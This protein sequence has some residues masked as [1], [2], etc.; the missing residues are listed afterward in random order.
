MA[1]LLF[2]QNIEYGFLGPM[3]IAAAIKQRHGC[4][5][6]IARKNGDV[7]AAIESYKPDVVGFSVMTGQH[8]WAVAAAGM[9]KRKYGNRVL[10][11]FGGPHPTFFSECIGSEGIDCICRGEGEDATLELLDAI[12]AGH[13]YSAIANL[14]VKK[15]DR[16]I[17]ND[18]RPLERGLDRYPFPDRELYRAIDAYSDSRIVNVITSRGCVYNCSF[19]FEESMRD[20]YRG[21]GCFAR[22]RTVENV[23]EELVQLKKTGAV[24]RI[25]FCDDIFGINKQWLYSFLE[26]YRTEIGLDFIC[27]IRADVVCSDPGYV[28]RLKDAGCKSVFFGIET[29]AQ[30]IRNAVLKKNLE[31]RHIYEA[32]R[33]LHDAGIP[34]RTYNILGLPDETLKDAYSTV[35]MNIDIRADYPW[36]SIFSPYPR[37]ALAEYAA[38]RGYIDARIDPDTLP[39][40]FFIESALK[41]PDIHRIENLQKMFQTAV[42]WP[43]TFPLIRLL[44]KLPPNMVFRLWFA[45]IYFYVHVRSENRSLFKTFL[46]ALRNWKHVL[47]KG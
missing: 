22:V 20:L 41:L 17:M 39:Q 2:V 29:G 25:Y 28:R 19:C 5:M 47:L 45:L 3:Y 23:L 14:C 40:S 46:F 31:D 12:D 4:E 30:S 24:Q 43:S 6:V 7:A 34:F 18:V 38:Q 44:I 27:L 13:D 35:Q 9:I 11:L 16:V 42:L 1:K 37:T 21:K 10:T 15:D 33:L 32:A 26:R 36:C 8:R